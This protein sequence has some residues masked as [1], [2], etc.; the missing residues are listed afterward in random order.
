MLVL[1][2]IVP[3]ANLGRDPPEKPM[4]N[5]PFCFTARADCSAVE[6]HRV[7]GRIRSVTSYNQ[8]RTEGEGDYRWRGL[9]HTDVPSEGIRNVGLGFVDS[10]YAL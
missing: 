7:Y 10:Y 8:R 1:E 6:V 3:Q 5:L 4:L 2:T 9:S